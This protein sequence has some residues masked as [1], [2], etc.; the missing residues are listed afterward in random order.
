MTGYDILLDLGQMLFYIIKPEQHH[1][2]YRYDRINPLVT[3]D[4]VVLN[5]CVLRNPGTVCC[6][7]DIAGR[8]QAEVE[9]TLCKAGT[10]GENDCVDRHGKAVSAEASLP[11][12][13][14]ES[15]GQHSHCNISQ[16]QCSE[17]TN[18]Q[19]RQYP[20]HICGIEQ[21]GKACSTGNSKACQHYAAFVELF[22]QGP[23][24]Q[25]TE[26]KRRIAYS[27]NKC[28][29]RAVVVG[30]K[31]P[32]A[33]IDKTRILEIVAQLDQDHCPHHD[34]PVSV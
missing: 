4:K 7:R 23:H 25:N 2:N 8:V 29:R 14:V 1:E 19:H 34:Q 27:R 9:D 17:G 33:V 5:C 22:D 18:G 31:H 20:A 15:I 11:F 28:L 32:V 21:E 6:R 24:E 10:D 30:A 26:A 16:G 13:V 3:P 12:H